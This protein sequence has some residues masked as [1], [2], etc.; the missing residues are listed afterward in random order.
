MR[1]SRPLLVPLRKQKRQQSRRNT[2]EIALLLI[3]ANAWIGTLAS[4]VAKVED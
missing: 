1:L 3:D 2:I 4:N